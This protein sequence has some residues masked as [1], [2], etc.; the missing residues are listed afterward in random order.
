MPDDYQEYEYGDGYFHEGGEFQIDLETPPTVSGVDFDDESFDVP[1]PT[2]S[3]PE[4]EELTD[5]EQETPALPE[6]QLPTDMEP[7]DAPGL[8]EPA[9]QDPNVFDGEVERPTSDD[10]STT[11]WAMDEA[12]P[13]PLDT[14]RPASDVPPLPESALQDP[15]TPFNEDIAPVVAPDT[16]SAPSSPAGAFGG[17]SGLPEPAS[18][19][20][21]PA[22]VNETSPSVGGAFTSH[23]YADESPS[24]SIP[25]DDVPKSYQPQW[26]NQNADGYFGNNVTENAGS[27]SVQGTDVDAEG[28]DLAAIE[29][30]AGD[31]NS[32]LTALQ[33]AVIEQ[34]HGIASRVREVASSVR[35]L[36][37]ARF[38]EQ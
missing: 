30:A 24:P 15:A 1:L 32:E 18:L 8:P 35:Q 38:A 27:Q 6:R 28:V 5:K 9:S 10:P 4:E 7:Y 26:D 22:P 20:T 3:M 2:G 11:P 17:G 25:M 31:V 29:S 14:V 37:D 33:D 13:T 21:P 19:L 34:F 12:Y 23:P 16:P 36:E